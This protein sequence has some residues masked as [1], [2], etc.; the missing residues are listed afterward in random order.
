MQSRRAVCMRALPFAAATCVFLA[1][2]AQKVKTA[3]TPAKNEARTLT[4]IQQAEG[5]PIEFRA[6]L[7]FEAIRSG[8][9]LSMRRRKLLLESLFQDAQSA[10]DAFKLR[11]VVRMPYLRAADVAAAHTLNLDQLSIR[12]RVVQD[13]LKIDPP[14]ARRLWND[15]Q[16]SLPP[17]PCSSPYAPDLSGYYLAL[18]DLLTH[19]FTPT[20]LAK[21][22]QVGLL[23]QEVQRAR[24]PMQ[25][26]QVGLLISE[27]GET[28]DQ[29]SR[30]AFLYTDLL[31]RTEAS[32]RELG[33]ISDRLPEAVTQL[34][35]ALKLRKQDPT[36]L[37]NAYRSFLVRS[38]KA[39]E[40][41]TQPADRTALIHSFPTN[42]FRSPSWITASFDQGS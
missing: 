1:A 18:K 33:A 42:P 39:G 41:G 21:G 13:L 23:Q 9:P 26:D 11:S 3:P 16:I 14:S 24:S 31:Q 25:L 35:L 34:A 5:L 2:Q 29:L 15:I 40:C 36:P 38:A 32:D 27:L 22:T 30:S 17:T 20:E 6:D 37:V 19:G 8:A 4:V 10:R 12:T 28:D 7:E